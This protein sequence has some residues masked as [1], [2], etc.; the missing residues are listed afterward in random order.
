LVYFLVKKITGS[1]GET[2]IHWTK[3]VFWS[4][5]KRQ[6]VTIVG[7]IG[8]VLLLI[9][10]QPRI[11]IHS[12][13]MVEAPTHIVYASESGFVQE[14]AFNDKRQVT[15]AAGEPIVVLSSPE[16]NLQ[17]LQLQNSQT[18]LQ[19][20][21]QEAQVAQERATARRLLIEQS[22]LDEQL[23]SL[24]QQNDSLVIPS[25]KGQWLVDGLPPQSLVG[26]YFALGE[27]IITLVAQRTRYIEV[28]VDQRDV[29][30]LSQ[31][32]RGLIRFAGVAAGL[33]D[34]TID[35]ISPLAK[36]DGTEQSILVRM[37]IELPQDVQTPPL[38]LSGDIV[39][40]G[41]PQPLWRHFFHSIR[42]VLRA[43]LWL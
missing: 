38:G 21:Q 10:W 13:G 29:Y 37:A 1:W 35:L 9:F 3:T 24:E 26:R 20:Q 23:K 8:L 42:K 2:L 41:Q 15:S 11:R 34:A 28:I 16:L 30:L 39:I 18:L 4:S 25:P 31:G 5:A 22:L 32:N 43:D 40:F 27:P 14:V 17:Q 36:L 7:L 12:N 6:K 33:Y 19:M